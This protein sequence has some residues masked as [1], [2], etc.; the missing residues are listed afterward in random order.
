MEEFN[1]EKKG[2]NIDS[3]KNIEQPG[4]TLEQQESIKGL[5]KKIALLL[6][7]SR[8]VDLGEGEVN[9][10]VL[11]KAIELA[12][13]TNDLFGKTLLENIGSL[14]DAFVNNKNVLRRAED[15]FREKKE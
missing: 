12:S 2:V 11:R 7:I 15:L 5:I 6:D 4:L 1:L 13:R 10:V 14:L 3:S 9:R 8:G